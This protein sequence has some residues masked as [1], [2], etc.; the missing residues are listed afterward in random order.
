[1]QIQPILHIF[2]DDPSWQEA[3][4]AHIVEVVL[5]TLKEKE[6]CSISLSGGSTPRQ[7]Y[8]K[9]AREGENRGLPW[10]SIRLFWGDERAVPYDHPDSNYRMVK[11]ALLDH[12]DIPDEN[13]FPVPNPENPVSAARGYEKM[14]QS[15]FSPGEYSFDLSLLGMGDDGH[16]ASIFP[17]TD[18]VKERKSWVREVYLQDQNMYRISVTA[19]VI[20]S[21]G[22]IAFLIKGANKAEAL[23]EVLEG[24]RNASQYP[25]Q[26]IRRSPH[27]H[28]FMD[29][30]AAKNL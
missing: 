12:V 5:E 7:I 25:S 15:Q 19:P 24:E 2:K 6:Y 28:Y 29:S 17:H 27:V 18:L 30:E 21:S 1:M 4:V 16:T 22:N 26:L 14:L 13:V 20:N 8:E 9:L 11:E 10:K 3:V 23:K